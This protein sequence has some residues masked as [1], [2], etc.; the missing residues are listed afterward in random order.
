MSHLTP[1]LRAALQRDAATIVSTSKRWS[2]QS[3][4][5][6]AVMA[7]SAV[8]E[9][10]NKIQDA[11]DPSSSN[12]NGYCIQHNKK[13]TSQTLLQCAVERLAQQHEFLQFWQE[14]SSGTT[15]AKQRPNHNHNNRK[16]LLDTLQYIHADTYQLGR[17]LLDNTAFWQRFAAPEQFT[18]NAVLKEVR[19]RH[20]TTL[21]TVVDLVNSSD[22]DNDYDDND[23]SCALLFLQ[24]RVGIQ[25][26]CDHHVELY[27]QQ[28]QTTKTTADN[29]N[30]QHRGA[31]TVNAPL[32]PILFEA[33]TEAQHVVD[34]H[35]Q[36]YPETRYFYYNDDHSNSSA[37][38]GRISGSDLPLY[39]G[40]GRC[41]VVRPW[42][43]HALVELLKNAMA[44]T[45][46]QMRHQH[47]SVPAPIDIIVTEPNTTNTPK[48]IEIDIV[49]RGTGI[50]DGD[51]GLARALALGH[52]SAH[53]RWD[54]LDE[55]QSYAAV[56]S[57]LSS[58][59]VGLP[60]SRIMMEHFGGRL[61]LRNNNSNDTGCTARIEWPVDETILE[62][63]PE[64]A[65]L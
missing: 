55:Q 9:Q 42:L 60:V 8:Q 53:R 39:D 10:L 31:V 62:R 1:Q 11:P 18:V 28:Q 43:H 6:L 45:V 26:L 54:R 24:R 50:A 41:T 32:F 2:L 40:C 15:T 17:R 27:R 29:N 34:A 23:H 52:S 36:I 47:E 38:N 65:V 37:G 51:S 19:A 44:A 63:D 22:D 30:N 5:E 25:L 49:D 21:E 35:L 12:N 56:R 7:P 57:P 4:A 64:V 58:L 20:A 13:T 48:R 46:Q 33:V 61:T 3:L 16:K 59:G 14:Q